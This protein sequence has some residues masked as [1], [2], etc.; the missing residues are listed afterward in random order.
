MTRKVMK[1]IDPGTGFMKCRVC[2]S[3]HCANL[4]R[5]GYCIRGSWQCKEGCKLPERDKPE[6]INTRR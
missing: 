1:L 3:V 6:A 4:H 2:G 5:G